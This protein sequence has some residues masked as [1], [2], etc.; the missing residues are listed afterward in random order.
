MSRTFLFA[1]RTGLQGTYITEVS[2]SEAMQAIRNN[3]KTGYQLGIM[4]GVSLASACKVYGEYAPYKK[5]DSVEE[6]LTN[7]QESARVQIQH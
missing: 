7:I 1:R 2:K 5:V 3:R 6:L 4:G